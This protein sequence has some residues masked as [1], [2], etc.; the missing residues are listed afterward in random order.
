MAVLVVDGAITLA[1]ALA[2][3]L[4]S[5]S[6]DILERVA[7][8]GAVVPG[9]WSLEVGNGMLSAVRQKRI[10]FEQVKTIL[11][12][13][14]ELPIVIDRRTHELAWGRVMSL[15]Q[16]HVLTTY[17]AAYLELAIRTESALATLDKALAKAA[18][19]EGVLVL[20]AR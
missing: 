6:L 12:D 16:R 9:I 3:E 1:W 13:I 17:D 5:D 14:S 20:P 19:G 10:K 2:D 11:A 8:H 15:A 4:D 7:R 18:E